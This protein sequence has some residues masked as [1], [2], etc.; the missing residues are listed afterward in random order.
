[1]LSMRI[2]FFDIAN[3]NWAFNVVNENYVFLFIFIL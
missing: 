3:E 2:D 1:M